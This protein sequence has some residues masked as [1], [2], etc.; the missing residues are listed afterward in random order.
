[1]LG[2]EHPGWAFRPHPQPLSVSTMRCHVEWMGLQSQGTRVQIPATPLLARDREQVKPSSL[3]T[4]SHH[5]FWPKITEVFQ[6]E[7]LGGVSHHR[8]P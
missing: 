2:C 8:H 7:G 4:W 6:Q 5:T 3:L 1:M